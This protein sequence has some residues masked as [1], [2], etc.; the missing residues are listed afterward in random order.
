MFLAEIFNLTNAVNYADYIGT[1]TS[2][3]FGNP[4]TAGPKRRLQLGFRLEF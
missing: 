3:Q 2:S 4:T 1:I